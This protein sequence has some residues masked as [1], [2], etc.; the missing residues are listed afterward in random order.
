M[1]EGLQAVGTMPSLGKEVFLRLLV[2]QLRYQDPLNPL[3]NT[4]FVAQLAQFSTLEGINNMEEELEKVRDSL[5]SLNNYSTTN[6][7]GKE[8]KAQGDTVSLV[9]GSAV[10]GY[11]L[12]EDATEVVVVIKDRNGKV[13]RTIEETNRRKGENLLTWDGRDEEG[14]PLP[15]GDYTF[16]VSARKGDEAVEAWPLIQGRVDGVVFK[17][18]RPYVTVEGRRVSIADIYEIR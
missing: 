6:L 9:D 18:G 4:E 13:V 1:S 10:M 15:P 17:G 8:V 3:K 7:I 11:R 16:T 14:R 5:L 2:T 12:G